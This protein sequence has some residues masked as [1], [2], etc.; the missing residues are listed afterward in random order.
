MFFLNGL[1]RHHHPVFEHPN[2]GRTGDDRYLVVIEVEDPKFD[3][4]ETKSFLKELG[5]KS[6]TMIRE[7][8]MN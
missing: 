1:P 6:L 2:F 8:V 4:E 7:P 5:G 3:D